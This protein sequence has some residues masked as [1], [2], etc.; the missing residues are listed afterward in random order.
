MISCVTVSTHA[1]PMIPDFS[2]RTFLMPSVRVM[3][4][5]Q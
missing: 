4:W 2:R 1:L 5:F 3:I